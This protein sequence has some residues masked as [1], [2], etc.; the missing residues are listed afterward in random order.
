MPDLEFSLIT[1]ADCE[2][3]QHAIRDA[4]LGE[5]STRGLAEIAAGEGLRV[6]LLAIPTD[7]EASPALYRELERDGHEIGLHVHPADQGY[8]EF[9]GVY[10][11]EDQKKIVG[12]AADRFAQVMGRRPANVCIGYGSANDHTY[13]VFAELG[14]RH[15]HISIPSRILPECASVWAGA[16]LECTTPI[17]Q[18]VLP[19]WLDFVEVPQTLDPDSA[20]GEASTRRTSVSNSWTPK[21]TGTRSPNPWTGRSA[22]RSA[23]QI[24]PYRDPQHFEFGKDGDFRRETLIKM[25]RQSRTSSPAGAALKPA[26]MADAA[27]AYRAG[28]RSRRPADS[29]WLDTRGRS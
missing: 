5:R 18:S 3:T 20:C 14:F 8:E 10:G 17:P 2:A 6:T 24:Y 16:P 15:G 9:L 7:L 11:P 29:S 1:R 12:E 21:T 19:G 13:P 4:A 25:I 27:G 28:V 23:R 26:T 22:R